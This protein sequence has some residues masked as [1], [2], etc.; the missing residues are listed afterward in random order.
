MRRAAG[1]AGYATFD[2]D[3]PAWHSA[4]AA[5]YAQATAPLRR[6]QDRYV[7]EATLAVVNGRPVPDEIAAAFP[8]LPAAMAHRRSSA[9]TG[10][11]AKLLDL[12][13]AVCLMGREGDIFDAVVIDE[14]DWGAE[15]QIAEPAVLARLS[16][17]GVD[18]GDDVRV[19]LVSVDVERG[20]IEFER[21]S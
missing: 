20:Q 14:G 10:Q 8:V 6:L 4:V 15:V 18:P 17:R 11:S 19:R 3:A 1:G 2:P 5:M 9:P 13:E 12:A 16:A 21:V 7:I